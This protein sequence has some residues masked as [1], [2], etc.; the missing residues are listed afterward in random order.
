MARTFRQQQLA[1]LAA[2]ERVMARLFSDLADR[3][4]GVLG[5][6]AGAD[7]RIPA[8][9]GVACR[10]EVGALV[11]ALFLSVSGGDLV[12]YT[13]T[14]DGTVIPLSPYM[15]QL[16]SACETATRIAVD[17]HASLMRRAL[18][19]EPGIIRALEVAR[20]NPFAAARRA[21]KEQTGFKAN[22]LAAYDPLHK[23]VHPD[24]YRLSDR[25]WRTSINTRRRIDLL[26]DEGIRQ[27]RGALDMSRDLQAFL[28]PGRGLRNTTRPYGTT[29]SY[30]AL[31]L[32]R[33]EI[34]AAA[35]RAWH[36]SAALNP[37]VQEYEWVMSGAHPKADI[38]DT[39]AAG[40]PYEVGDMSAPMPPAHPSCLCHTQAV[41]VGN[42]ADLV[43]D[44]RAEL[45]T[46]AVLRVDSLIDIAGPM[47]GALFARYL[48]GW[49]G[50]AVYADE[51]AA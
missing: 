25:I 27:G 32:A 26:L 8:R 1:T 43:A 38:C 11:T 5:R 35:S 10:G 17:Q 30:D 7:G 40:G 37:F 33:T 3:I 51:Y 44:L 9:R 24:G 15:R 41:L 46:P 16:W 47:A 22:P 42:V 50:E 49:Q 34:T 18:R 20:G 12:A 19:N 14:Q 28:Q 39:Y 4:G 48:M 31:R 2:N 45:E 21:V 29:A 6:Y 13:E 36:A 23:F